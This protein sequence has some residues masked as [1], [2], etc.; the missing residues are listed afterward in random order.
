MDKHTCKFFGYACLSMKL[1]LVGS[2]GHRRLLVCSH[3]QYVDHLHSDSAV[4]SSSE[5]K[6]LISACVQHYLSQSEGN[7]HRQPPP[8][9]RTQSTLMGAPEVRPRLHRLPWQPLDLDRHLLFVSQQMLTS[10]ALLQTAMLAAWAPLERRL[11]L[12]S[13]NSVFVSVISQ[14]RSDSARRLRGSP[15]PPTL[16][17]ILHASRQNLKLGFEMCCFAGLLD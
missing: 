6:R 15:S 11:S 12:C 14:Q 16:S 9:L 2:A 1:L 13:I 8:Y 3:K 7:W 10:A 5:G 17:T 4:C